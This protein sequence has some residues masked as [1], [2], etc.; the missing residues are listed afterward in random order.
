MKYFCCLIKLIFPFFGEVV[1]SSSLTFQGVFCIS[2][3]NIS[4]FE[5][6]FLWNRSWSGLYATDCDERVWKA[7]E[8]GRRVGHLHPCNLSSHTAD[9][10]N[11]EFD[12]KSR[13]LYTLSHCARWKVFVTL[14]SWT[15]LWIVG[16][17]IQL[18]DTRWLLYK[19]LI[20]F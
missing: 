10:A 13:T 1:E 3:F 7:P 5:S 20:T 19:V 11:L 16:K 9:I 6:F 18:S 2:L 17:I 8:A 4:G 12:S 15:V 14:S